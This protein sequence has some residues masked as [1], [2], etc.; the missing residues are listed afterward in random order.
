MVWFYQRGTESLQLETRCDNTNGGFLLIT[1]SAD[2]QRQVEQFP[3]A[4]SFRRRL[5]ALEAR[6]QAD[7]WTWLGLLLLPH[8]GKVS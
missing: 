6:L 4:I 1:I 8:G 2:R 5:E 3:D 7:C